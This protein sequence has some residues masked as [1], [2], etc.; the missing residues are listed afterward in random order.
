MPDPLKILL[1]IDVTHPNQDLLTSLKR[2]VSC[3]DASIKLLYVKEDLPSYEGILGAIGDFPDDWMRQVEMKAR[4]CLEEIASQLKSLCHD[5]TIE[6]VS[7][8]PAMMIESVARDEGFN[9]TVLTPGKH[10]KV[11]QF[12]LGSTCQNVIKRGPGT[13]LILRQSSSSSDV[14]RHIIIGVDGS[15]GSRHAIKSAAQQFCIDR[16]TTKVSLVH[17]VAIAGIWK[18]V[19]PVQFVAALEDNLTMLGETFLAEGEKIL[20]EEGISNIELVLKSGDPAEEIIDLGKKSHADLIVTGAQNHKAVEHFFLGSVPDR[21]AM[22]APCSS[23][24]VKQ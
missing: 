2:M 6:I 7:G 1:P 14:L 13:V 17:V 20:T 3:A 8:P 19:S 15:L 23:A 5:V 12:L 22:H 11:Q 24:V 10:S 21:I 4:A 9:I 18:Y 16:K